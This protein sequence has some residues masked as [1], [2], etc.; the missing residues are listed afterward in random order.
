[1]R[2]FQDTFET[3]KR[4]FFSAF[5]ICITV[6][7]MGNF[8]FCEVSYNHKLSRHNDLGYFEFEFMSI[9]LFIYFLAKQ[10]QTKYDLTI[11]TGSDEWAGTQ[12]NI[13]IKLFGEKGDSRVIKLPE[14]SD[15][16]AQSK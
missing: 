11:Y 6:T 14:N 3:R 16:Y 5:S 2:N 4:S 13:F 15:N 7:L 8:I 9:F 12:A 10:K 1:M